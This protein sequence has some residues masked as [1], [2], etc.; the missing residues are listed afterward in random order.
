[1]ACTST[2]HRTM[3]NPLSGLT[4]TLQGVRVLN[5]LVRVVPL[6]VPS[7]NLPPLFLSRRSATWTKTTTRVSPRY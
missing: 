5:L 6:S 2:D 3:A 1:M 7:T 4:P